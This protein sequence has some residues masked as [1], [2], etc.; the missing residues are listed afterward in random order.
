K[1]KKDKLIGTVVDPT[2]RFH[3]AAWSRLEGE[4]ADFRQREAQRVAGETASEAMRVA[5]AKG[6]ALMMLGIAGA[7]LGFFLVLAL[8]LIFAKIE[9]NLR[10]IHKGIDRHEPQ[11][12]AG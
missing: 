1:L 3:A 6:K 11:P 8:Y 10:L 4:K 9:D 5:A 12:V 7:L 2:I